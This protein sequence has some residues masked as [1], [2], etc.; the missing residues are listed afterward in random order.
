[1]IWATKR[2]HRDEIPSI[3]HLFRDQAAAFDPHHQMLL[4]SADEED[5]MA[6][7]WIAVPDYDLLTPYYGFEPCQRGQLPAAPILIAGNTERFAAI[8]HMV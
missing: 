1:M 8:F 2:M 5:W 7:L 6:R 3:E 4:I